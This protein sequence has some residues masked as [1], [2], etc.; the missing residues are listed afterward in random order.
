MTITS[1]AHPNHNPDPVTIEGRRLQ[2]K[3]IFITGASTGIGAAAARRFVAEGAAVIVGARRKDRLDALVDDLT[4]AGGE[5]LAVALDVSDEDSVAAAVAAAVERY[6][7]LDGAL[8][9]AA[10]VG[11]GKPI[12]ESDSDY[13]RQVIDV[14]LTGVYY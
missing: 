11:A 10:L 14:N 12:V 2:D 6:G 5:A 1:T 7:R 13:F 3:V 9:N 8:N 4:G